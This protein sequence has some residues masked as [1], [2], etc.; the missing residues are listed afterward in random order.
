MHPM[1][2]PNPKSI[3]DLAAELDSPAD[4]EAYLAAA[5]DGHPGIRRQVDGL[6]RALHQAGSLLARLLDAGTTA[7]GAPYCVMELVRGVSITEFCDAHRL[8]VPERLRL[9]QQVCGAVHHA[10]Q[11]GVI[12]RD[13]KPS[14]ILVE[15][16]D[17]T[18][19]PKV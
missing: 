10:H 12:H 2:A 4:R 9:F 15:S 7:D 18:P 8:N 3:F 13:L 6:L 17:G 19:V 14:N 11:K 5:C 16:H 1:T